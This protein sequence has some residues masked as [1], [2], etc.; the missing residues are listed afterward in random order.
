MFPYKTS[1]SKSYVKVNRMGSAK[2]TNHKER[3]FATNCFIFSYFL[4]CSIFNVSYFC[5]LSYIILPKFLC[6]INNWHNK[7][8]HD[9]FENNFIVYCTKNFW[10]YYIRLCTKVWY[11]ENWAIEK[12]WKVKGKDQES[13]INCFICLKTWF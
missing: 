5:T 8:L 11:I 13:G 6:T 7:Q 12:I 2:W 4:I 10:L 9:W 1:L 3:S